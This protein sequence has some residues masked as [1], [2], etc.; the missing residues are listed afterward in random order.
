MAPVIKEC[1]LRNINF[2]ILHTNQ[3]YSFQL[4]N[5][6]FNDLGLPKQK[7]NLN[8][9]SGRHGEQ[10]AKMLARIERCLLIEKPDVVLVEGDTNSVLA[11]ALAASKLHIKIGHIEAGLRSYSRE[12][13]EETNRIIV[14]HIS[15][16][17][18]C[19][20]RLSAKTLLKEGIDNKN[21][22]VTGN[23]IVDAVY[24]NL[25]LARKSKILK[26]LSLSEK[27]YVLLTAHREENVDN[28][29]KIENIFNGV[30]KIYKKYK[31]KIIYPIHPRTKKMIKKYKVKIPEGLILIEPVG[32]F[33]FLTLEQKAC[34]ILTDSGG[35][36]EEACILNVPCVTLRE[37][38]E[39]PETLKV[40]SN[41]LSGTNSEKILKYAAF[42]LK[43]NKNWKNPFGDGKA[44]KKIINALI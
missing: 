12:M 2:F 5:I 30:Q 23:T 9:G 40:N 10:T 1:Q 20:T 26:K 13:P 16:Y 17:L 34:L 15:D 43:N 29:I 4:D 39:R 31:L 35:I 33:D 44:S 25:Q 11:G 24:Q 41:I 7:Y 8:V 18:F 36:Q 14:D 22:I 3:H 32:Y 28:K 19:P 38:T 6:F 27:N 42:M 21:I 37:N